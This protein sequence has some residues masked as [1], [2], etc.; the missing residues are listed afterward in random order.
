M[1]ALRDSIGPDLWK[2]PNRFFSAN[3]LLAKAKILSIGP[4]NSRWRRQWRERWK[5][6]GIW[7]S[8]PYRRGQIAGVLGPAVQFAL[9]QKKAI[10]STHTINLQE[11]LLYKDIPILQKVR[12]ELSRRRD[13]RPAELCLSAPATA[14]REQQNDLFT[15]PEQNELEEIS[16]WAARTRDGTLSDLSFEPNVKFGGK[17]AARPTLAP[18]NLWASD[19]CFYQR[20]RRKFESAPIVVINHRS[21]SCS[22]VAWRSR[23][24]GRPD[25]CSPTIF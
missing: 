21:F 20:A 24:N 6:S 9:E 8:K 18:R 3:G 5:R 19:R 4:N 23:W 15:G 2:Q 16:V 10:I 17:F 11:Q 25:F 12:P 13:Q 1:I 22:W 14:A 7:W